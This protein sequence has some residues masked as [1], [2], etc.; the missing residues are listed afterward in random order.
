[1]KVKTPFKRALLAAARAL[2]AIWSLI[3]ARPRRTLI[4]GLIVVE[5]RADAPPVALKRLFGVLDDVERVIAERA[6]AYGNGINPKHR[7]IGYHDFF[8]ERIPAGSRVL[9][10]GCGVGEV[11]RSIARRVPGAAVTAID[12]E[13]R[14]LEMA[15][16]GEVP[17]NLTFVEGDATRDLAAEHWDVIVLSNILEHVDER[18][19]LLTELIHRNTPGRILVRVPVFER[20]WHL[21]LRR[22]LGVGY[23]SDP[24]HRIE[25]TLAE[26]ESETT[27]AGLRVVE[28]QIIWGE[29]WA[30]CEP[31]G[32][33]P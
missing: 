23:F 25:H 1:M 17:A 8:V 19:G 16:Q 12:K 9:D 32:S 27:A 22:E 26:F 31:V 29:I 10:V 15:R 7:L 24:T 13:A 21:P 11:A 3:P 33:T 28:R 30:H 6:T 14:L 2:G 4:H 20:H 5:S 18:V